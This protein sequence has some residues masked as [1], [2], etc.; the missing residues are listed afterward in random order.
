MP[1]VSRKHIKDSDVFT[2][3]EVKQAILIREVADGF[4]STTFLILGLS[5]LST[6]TL[7]T[8]LIANVKEDNVHLD[9]IGDRYESANSDIEGFTKWYRKQN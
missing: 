5:I 1:L 3:S 2:G 7:S 6:F 8:V 4:I 9:I